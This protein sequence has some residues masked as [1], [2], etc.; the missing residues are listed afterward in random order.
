M[1]FSTEGMWANR[2]RA[3]A[4]GKAKRWDKLRVEATDKAKGQVALRAGTAGGEGRPH[5][6]TGAGQQ[7]ARGASGRD[8]C[9]P[10]E[11]GAQMGRWTQA[12][13]IWASEFS[14]AR[15]QM[16]ASARSTSYRKIGTCIL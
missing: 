2:I 3:R 1:I 11:A 5:R 13:S 16:T 12:L 7:E 4:P 9:P 15:I 14:T 8:G 6:A 10:G